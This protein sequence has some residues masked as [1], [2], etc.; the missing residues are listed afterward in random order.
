VVE[1]DNTTVDSTV[2]TKRP[3]FVGDHFQGINVFLV[4]VFLALGS[5]MEV[6]IVFM[7]KQLKSASFKVKL[8]KVLIESVDSIV[9]IGRVGVDDEMVGEESVNFHEPVSIE[10]NSFADFACRQVL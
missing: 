5:G 1:P 9:V 10:G 2:V 6:Q 4:F 7:V 3:D 8:K